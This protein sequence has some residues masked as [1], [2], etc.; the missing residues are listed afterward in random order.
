MLRGSLFRIAHLSLFSLPQANAA[1]SRPHPGDLEEPDDNEDD[2]DDIQNGLDAG[3]H[4]D[5]AI[6]EPQN[7]PNHYQHEH[8]IH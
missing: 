8:D 5:V 7:Q 6:D 2:N 4:W 1:H 3:R